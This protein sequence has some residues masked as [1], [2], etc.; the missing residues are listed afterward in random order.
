MTT[1]SGYGP[2]FGGRD[3][4]FRKPLADQAQYAKK[5]K[6]RAAKLPHMKPKGKRGKAQVKR[7]GRNFKT[8]G[9]KKIA[10]KASSEYESKEAG[11]RVAGAVFN[12]MAKARGHAR[13][14]KKYAHKGHAHRSRK[15]MKAC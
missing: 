12:K 11:E 8:G 1:A 14:G 6:K 4:Y 9:F 13:K 15:A 10:E 5:G 2:G 3:D 7:L